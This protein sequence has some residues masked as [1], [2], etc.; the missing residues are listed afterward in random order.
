ML[1]LVE[2][3]LETYKHKTQNKELSFFPIDL[4]EL[5]R[6]VLEELRSLATQK[7]L[8]LRLVSDRSIRVMGDRLELY[9]L[10][11]NLV[12]N[13]IRFTDTGFVEIQLRRR[14][15]RAVIKVV[16]TGLGMSEAE[17]EQI[18]EQFTPRQNSRSGSGLGL[19]LCQQI[20]EAHQGSIQVRSTR[21]IGTTFTIQIPALE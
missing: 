15:E 16:D 20:V 6:A 13:A 11:T 10:L 14:S 4:V 7:G 8:E 5:S 17:Q 2:N 21:A 12:S 3:V 19:Y 1:T 9:R 18:F